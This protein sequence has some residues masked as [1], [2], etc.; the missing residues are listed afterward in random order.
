[1][2]LLCA[3]PPGL[4]DAR[5]SEG[6]RLVRDRLMRFFCVCEHFE[7]IGDRMMEF[8]EILDVVTALDP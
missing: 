6:F 5:R 3:A 2:R 7:Q 8:V 4:S 1:M